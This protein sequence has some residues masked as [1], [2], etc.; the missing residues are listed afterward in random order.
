MTRATKSTSSPG[1]I[2]YTTRARSCTITATSSIRLRPTESLRCPSTNMPTST[3]MMPV[4]NTIVTSA[5]GKP[6]TFSY[7]P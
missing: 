3:P 2:A 1:E 6:S 7:V 4:E 5:V